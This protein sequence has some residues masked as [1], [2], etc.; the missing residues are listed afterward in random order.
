MVHAETVRVLLVEDDEDD[1]I[2]ARDL[3]KEIPGE[4][5]DVEWAQTFEAGLEALLRNQHDVC[6]LDYRLGA[7]TGLELLRTA[8]A[9]GCPAPIILLTGLGERKIDLEAMQAGAADYLVKSQLRADGLGRSIRYALERQRAAAQAAFEQARLAAF[10]TEIGLALTSREP[11]QALLERCAQAMAQFLNA[12]LTQIAL[13]NPQTKAFE[14]RAKAGLL[15]AS[16][17]SPDKLPVLRLEPV[18]LTQ[19]R[20]VLIKDL[21]QDPRGSQLGWCL[22]EGLVSYAAY[23]LVLEEKLLGLMALFSDQPLSE[24][25][26]QD[27]GSVANGLALGIDRKLSGEALD[28][29]EGQYRAV[30]EN[31]KEVIFQ[32]DSFGN[33]LFLNPA[34]TAVTGFEVKPT[35]GTFFLEYILSEEREHNRMVFLKLLEKQLEYCRYETR[36]VT[37]NGKPRWV[38]VYAQP[39]PEK[40][41]QVPGISGTL[42]DITERKNAELQIQKLAAFPKLSPNPV[43]EFAHDGT[44]TYANEAALEMAHSFG[45]KE[46]PAILPPQASDL[47]RQCLATAQKQLRQEVRLDGRILTWSFFP[48]A[49]SQVVHC[50][51]A[52]VTEIQNLEAQLRHAQKLESVGQLA[53]GVAHDFNNILTIIQGYAEC[54]LAQHSEDAALTHPL[55]QIT[56]ASKRAA[57]LTRQLLT[58]SRRQLIQLRPLDLNNVLQDLVRTLG[59]LVGQEVALDHTYEPNLPAIEADT[60]MLEQIVMNLA[61]N[62]RDA[63]PKGGRLR[64]ATRRVQVTAEHVWR[65]ADA[66]P[67]SFVCLAVS[68]TGCGMDAHTRERIFEP[69]FTTKD[70][71]KGTGLGLATVYGIVKQHQGWIEVTTAPGQGASFEIYF[72]TL[73]TATA[74][75][76]STPSPAPPRA[77]HETILLVEDDA[78]LRE[79]VREVLLQHHYR[80]L[81]AGSGV[82]ALRLWDEQG[83]AVDLLLTDMVMPE[84]MSGRDLAEQLKRRKPGLKIIYSSGYS[85]EILG[86]DFALQGAL[87]L[88]KPYNPSQLAELVRQCLGAAPAAATSAACPP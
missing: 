88:P 86:S 64:L 83:E 46:L 51:G 15:A 80:I 61:V 35:L 8:I 26:W 73:Q 53:A 59:R 85:A 6:L 41:G 54:L 16:L 87:F 28:R 84:G 20:P 33:W 65:N 18:P 62:A 78:I 45:Q 68:D 43:L 60:G 67:G 22:R 49:P 24:K 30:I 23:P 2:L 37:R 32:L 11:L 71:G 9:K 56:L 34:W 38:E 13:F 77:G 69:F 74:A 1:F 36:L 44:L 25:I 31:I 19:G 7:H 58:F 5:F 27:M 81:E 4:R 76:T 14:P 39:L 40:D 12:P 48:I 66:R 75:A 63:M 70:V 72:P 47:A 57:G 21:S 29:S 3:F 42:M 17:D 50:Y 10:G 82:E 52:D 55:K 79:M